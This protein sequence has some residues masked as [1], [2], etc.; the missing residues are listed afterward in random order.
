MWREIV[1]SPKRKHV[2]ERHFLQWIQDDLILQRTCLSTLAYP[3][4]KW[5]VSKT[6]TSKPQTLELRPQTSK[7]QTPRKLRPWKLWSVTV[8]CSCSEDSKLEQNERRTARDSVKSSS[9]F[10]LFRGHLFHRILG[11][12]RYQ[13]LKRFKINDLLERNR[14]ILLRPKLWVKTCSTLFA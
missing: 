14:T 2:A 4:H 7:T 1:S 6:Q 13:Q 5:G 12:I 10:G 11:C 3:R 9:K 8:R